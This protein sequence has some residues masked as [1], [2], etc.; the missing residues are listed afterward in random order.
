MAL[1]DPATA[2]IAKA[3]SK[4]GKR[5]KQRDY[6][7]MVKCETVGDVVQYLKTYTHYQEYLDK[8]SSDIH[9]GSLENILREKQFESFLTFSKYNTG[10]T[11]VTRYILRA[12]CLSV[13]SVDSF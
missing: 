4:Y 9:R 2:I 1:I 3:K 12:L 7:A 6:S 10:N 5:L 8:V 11:P 13:G